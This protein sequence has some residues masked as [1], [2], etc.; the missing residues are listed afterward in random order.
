MLGLKPLQ[1]V[2]IVSFPKLFNVVIIILLFSSLFQK[3]RA[4]AFVWLDF[5]AKVDR[6]RVADHNLPS[7][8]STTC[9]MSPATFQ[10]TLLET[11]PQVTFTTTWATYFE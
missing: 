10:S 3:T 6:E 7:T 9:R 1:L 8:S 5:G 11:T 4:R 2:Q